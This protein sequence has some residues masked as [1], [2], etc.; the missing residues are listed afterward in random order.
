MEGAQ[1]MNPVFQKMSKVDASRTDPEAPEVGFLTVYLDSPVTAKGSRY[2]ETCVVKIPE[3]RLPQWLKPLMPRLRRL[4]SATDPN[5]GFVTDS[6]AYLGADGY[7]AF[8]PGDGPTL[9][10]YIKRLVQ[11]AGWALDEFPSKKR[12]EAWPIPAEHWKKV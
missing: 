10:Q 3:G 11:R 12:F 2:P 5:Y 9:Y 4:Q 8:S 6:Y 1:G 7:V